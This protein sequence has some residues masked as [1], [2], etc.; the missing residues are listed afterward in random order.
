MSVLGIFACSR[1]LMRMQTE[2]P[3]APTSG[4]DWPLLIH[5]LWLTVAAGW[6]GSC[7]AALRSF[8]E[9]HGNGF[10]FDGLDSVRLQWPQRDKPVERFSATLAPTFLLR[11]VLGALIAP[12]TFFVLHTGAA[13]F[14][15]ST[16]FGNPSKAAVSALATGGLAG[17]FAKSIWEGLK[18]RSKDLFKDPTGGSSAKEK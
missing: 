1:I 13:T 4:S 18:K 9:R 3:E 17:M 10:E 16:E 2:V 12:I 11:P 7:A 5:L 14:G 15:G 6:T 8:L